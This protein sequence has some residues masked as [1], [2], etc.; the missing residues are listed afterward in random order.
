M[1]GDLQ[2][3][4]EHGQPTSVGGLLTDPAWLV[5]ADPR[6][7]FAVLDDA[8]SLGEGAAA[9]VYRAS[10]EVHRKQNAG[11][12]RFV[13]AVDAARFG[14]RVLAA[15]FAAVDV[16]GERPVGWQVA[17]ATGSLAD[18]RL[19]RTLTGHEGWVTTVA[20][21]VAGG[22][23]VAVTGSR[24]NSVRVWD[25]AA[26]REVCVPLI[27][28]T[29]TWTSQTAE[30]AYVATA[31]V[32]GRDVALLLEQLHGEE[33]VLLLDLA[34]GSPTGECVRV[35]DVTEW[36]GL[37]VVLTVENDRTLRLWSVATGDEIGSSLPARILN[38]PDEDPVA[39]SAE[40]GGVARV[41]DWAGDVLESA[42]VDDAGDLSDAPASAVVVDGQLVAVAFD[43]FGIDGF[44]DGE[45]AVTVMGD[46]AAACGRPCGE[47]VAVSHLVEAEGRPVSLVR[48]PGG[49]LRVWDRVKGCRIGE[50]GWGVRTA[51]L[52]GQPIRLPHEGRSQE[53]RVWQLAHPAAVLGEDVI[54][55]LRSASVVGTG[56]VGGRALWLATD[57][58]H[59]VR[60]WDATTGAAV[61]ER[62][63]G[64]TDRV[65]AAAAVAVDERVVAV[66]AGLDRTVRVWDVATGRQI[67]GPLNGH[68]AQ[69]WDVATA[70]VDGRPVAVTAG[71]DCTVRVWDLGQGRGGHRPVFG[72]HDEAVLAAAT[73]T[74]HG[75]PV[76]V[77]A[78]ADETVRAW[79]LAG[80]APVAEHI[81]TEVCAMVA[82][83]VDGCA[84]VVTAAPDATIRRWDLASGQEI[85]RPL[86]G[87]T[88]RILT[89]ATA[90]VEG[91]SVA[92]TGG[93]DGTAHV[94]DLAT[95]RPFGPPLTGH[96]SRI[97][98]LATA[99]ADGRALAVTGSWDKTVRLWD[100]TTGRQI[101]EP[102]TGHTDWVTSLSTTAMNGH[103]VAVTAG[104]DATVRTWSLLDCKQIGEPLPCP[105][106]T[107]HGMTTVAN[108]NS[109]YLI[110]TCGSEEV[111]VRDLATGAEIASP[112][113]FPSPVQ[114]LLAAP[115]G[116]LVVGFGREIALLAPLT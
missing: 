5:N 110:T 111:S 51:A 38:G 98:A 75:R 25:L 24:D 23:A 11:Q 33:R 105:A 91:R 66:T 15:R 59:G 101:G 112:L 14:E 30:V 13:L 36:D 19:L 114:A 31:A 102:L 83:E 4:G 22:R 72:G 2:G 70:T 116:R 58:D 104:R 34:D 26:G 29:D 99:H 61:G 82:A 92:V 95:G 32:D 17:W 6:E 60:L 71:A 52:C 55:R 100:L 53:Y 43:A 86:A 109:P 81:A 39:V 28:R 48:G 79:D 108:G 88:G 42:P 18:V 107:V 113:A 56:V 69:V 68:T 97:T 93:S 21:A 46:L 47:V 94:W 8:V 27:C 20:T 89:M 16:P 77:T 85:G 37:G 41:W 78:G 65:R 63:A 74:L 40:L 96:T 57:A 67:G 44:H 12:R 80:G 106:G 115:D 73:T 76:V 87:H 35:V 84:V 54:A 49:S 9:V 64:H 45:T 62:L 10:A 90:Q 1:D 7:V 103:P 3:D 50:T